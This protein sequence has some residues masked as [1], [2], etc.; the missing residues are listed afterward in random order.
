MTLESMMCSFLAVLTPTA[1]HLSLYVYRSQDTFLSQELST[2]TTFYNNPFNLC[3]NASGLNHAE[4]GL[5]PGCEPV[6]VKQGE[7]GWDHRASS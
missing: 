5:L 4:L 6:T 7:A 1:H 2:T 3:Q